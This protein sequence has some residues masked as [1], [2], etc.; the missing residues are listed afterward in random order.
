MA[1]IFSASSDKMSGQRSSRIIGPLVRWLIPNIS[2][3]ALDRVVHTVRKIAHVTEYAI[4]AVL[5]WRALRTLQ[6]LGVGRAVP[7]APAFPRPWRWPVAIGAFALAALY[8]ITDEFHQSFVPSRQ[9]QV[10]DVLLDSFGA[11][12]GLLALWLF[13]RWRKYW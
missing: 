3:E 13:G 12:I 4:L 5:L 9:G 1:L 10:F 2:K 8:A 7:S 6:P 11:A